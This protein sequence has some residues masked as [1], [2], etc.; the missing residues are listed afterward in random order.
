MGLWLQQMAKTMGELQIKGAMDDK[1]SYFK[2]I[3][4]ESFTEMVGL[5]LGM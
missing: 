1:A 3:I 4:P 2:T 5:K